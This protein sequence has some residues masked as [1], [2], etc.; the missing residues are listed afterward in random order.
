MQTR[1]TKIQFIFL[2]IDLIILNVVIFY[3]GW[4]RL[5]IVLRN[6]HESSIYLLISNL[7]L[8][9]SYAIFARDNLYMRDTYLSR[10]KIISVKTLNLT[11]ILGFLIAFLLPG[12]Y[13]PYF[14]FQCIGLFYLCKLIFFKVLYLILKYRRA[15]GKHINRVLIVGDDE[16]TGLLK[17]MI[18]ANP[19]LGYQFAG[20]V[21]NN[22]E[23]E[24][25]VGTPGQLA[26]LIKKHQIQ[27]VFV[28]TSL[29]ADHFK[30]R[31]YLEICSSMCVRLRFATMNPSETKSLKGKEALGHITLIDPL[32]FPLDNW[33]L[34]IWKRLA[35]IFISSVAIAFIFSWLFPII[36]VLIKLSSKGPVFFI[37]KRTGL[38]KKTFNCIKFR[39][40]NVNKQANSLQAQLN[41][42]RITAIGQFLRKSNLDELP[43]FFNVFMGQ[44][45]VVGPR[46]HM[47]RHTGQ[48][49]KLIDQYLIRHYIKP[50]ITGWAQVNGYRGE[51]NELWKMQKRVDYDL[52]YIENWHFWWDFVII[53]KT[54][55]SANAY[56]HS[57]INHQLTK[58]ITA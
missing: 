6:Y 20:F 40:M 45:S 15:K 14:L 49:S 11:L 54:I 18:E 7:A 23:K 19:L 43:Q 17:N 28:S 48:Y 56:E 5:D 37:Q 32:E 38:N 36:A 57:G 35:D 25:T 8:F 39:S 29:F 21:S 47:L 34:R 27:M 1:E 16:N 13:S 41:D 42:S 53:W 4:L 52:E 3:L 46:P 9:L 2:F 33:S 26:Q 22:L 51:T 10:V 55:F 12:Q 30:N 58:K 44:M 50:G 24:E 31:Q